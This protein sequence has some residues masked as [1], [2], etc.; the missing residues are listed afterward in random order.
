MPVNKNRGCLKS[1]RQPHFSSEGYVDIF[2]QATHGPS[3][4]FRYPPFVFEQGKSDTCV[5]IKVILAPI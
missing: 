1:E 4:I 3:K 5:T 2:V